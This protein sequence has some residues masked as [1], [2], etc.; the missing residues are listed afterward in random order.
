[1]VRDSPFGFPADPYYT[2][3]GPS[4]QCFSPVFEGVFVS[5]PCGAENILSIRAEMPIIY[6]GA[7]V[8]AVWSERGQETATADAPRLGQS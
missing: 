7:S 2:S 1:M 4:V 3:D 8:C 6:N 5:L